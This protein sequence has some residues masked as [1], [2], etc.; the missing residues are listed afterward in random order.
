M[1]RGRLDSGRVSEPVM[2]VGRLKDPGV[3]D[4]DDKVMEIRGWHEE[5]QKEPEAMMTEEARSCNSASSGWATMIGLESDSVR[6]RTA[7]ECPRW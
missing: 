5:R 3:D 1:E 6:W 4:Y 7:M 2:G